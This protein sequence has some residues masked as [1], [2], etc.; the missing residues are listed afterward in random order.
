MAF[1]QSRFHFSRS[2]YHLTYDD[3]RQSEYPVERHWGHFRIVQRYAL[4]YHAIPTWCNWRRML[5]SCGMFLLR[6]SNPFVKHARLISLSIQRNNRLNLSSAVKK[7]FICTYLST[8]GQ[9]CWDK[10]DKTNKSY[11]ILS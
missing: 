6:F 10:F 1:W 9:L 5:A 11:S 7:T 4:Q 3:V 2:S 8:A